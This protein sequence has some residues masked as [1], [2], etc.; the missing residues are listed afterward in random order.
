MM[1]AVPVDTRS[2]YDK[3]MQMRGLHVAQKMDLLEVFTGCEMKN[4]YF[5]SE[6]NEDGK[7]ADG[8][9]LFR[10]KEET[11]ICERLFCKGAMRPLDINVFHEA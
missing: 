9:P 6:L 1:V 10:C 3:L 2:G 7:T 11:G 8:W 5:V 4:K